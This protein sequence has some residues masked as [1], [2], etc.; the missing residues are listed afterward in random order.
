MYTFL[1]EIGEQVVVRIV[2]WPYGDR[3][4][5]ASIF[6]HISEL[7]MDLRRRG[8]SFA[9]LR[10]LGNTTSALKDTTPWRATAAGQSMVDEER[11]AYIVVLVSLLLS[12]MDSQH[13]ADT[14]TDLKCTTRRSKRPFFHE[15]AITVFLRGRF[16]IQWLQ[17][18]VVPNTIE[19]DSPAYLIIRSCFVL[20]KQLAIVLSS[21]H[22]DSCV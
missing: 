7:K 11:D 2:N 1:P 22:S 17:N 21:Y 14:V 10:L 6:E 18:A 19:L 20:L 3:M 5:P 8:A 15:R 13:F 4:P 9:R 12:G 16:V